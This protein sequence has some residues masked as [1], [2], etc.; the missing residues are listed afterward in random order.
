MWKGGW[1]L[2]ESYVGLGD[3]V[4]GGHCVR[5]VCEVKIGVLMRRGNTRT[6]GNSLLAEW[7]L[8]GIEVLLGLRRMELYNSKN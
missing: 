1:E 7:K 3:W 8:G 4:G 6:G 2:V 5:L